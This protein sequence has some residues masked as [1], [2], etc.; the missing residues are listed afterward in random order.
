M[1]DAAGNAITHDAAART[2]CVSCI[3]NTSGTTQPWA[4]G[5]CVYNATYMQYL[6][7]GIITAL[8]GVQAQCYQRTG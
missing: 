3:Q 4:L 1:S 7:N 8:T 2:S 6:D 5:Q